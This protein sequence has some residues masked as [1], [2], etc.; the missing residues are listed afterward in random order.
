M[1]TANYQFPLLSIFKFTYEVKFTID[2]SHYALHKG[3]EPLFTAR[4]AAVLNHWR[5][6]Q[7]V[8]K[9]RF[10][11]ATSRVQG[12]ET[13]TVIFP[14]LQI[15]F[16]ILFRETVGSEIFPWTFAVYARLFIIT[17]IFSFEFTNALHFELAVPERQS[18]RLAITSI[19][20]F[21]RR[22]KELNLHYCRRTH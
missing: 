12:G 22:A 16:K 4:K 7:I 3:I 14:V 21:L 20:L 6:E 8:W 13:T 18:G 11:L 15:H 17:Y 19:D 5:M 1:W 2:H 9:A 10:E